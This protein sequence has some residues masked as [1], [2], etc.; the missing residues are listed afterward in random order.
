MFSKRG[1]IGFCARLK[2]NKTSLR[3][4]VIA[5]TYSMALFN[6]KTMKSSIIAISLCIFVV[7][8]PRAL[9]A[10]EIET[11]IANAAAQAYIKT[12]TV[13]VMNSYL[14]NTFNL[15]SG[16]S[17]ANPATKVLSI[18]EL[19]VSLDSLSK[20]D[21]DK[22]KFYATLKTIASAVSF[23]DPVTG[24][25][26]QFSVMI[27]SL[28][29][30]HLSLEHQEKMLTLMTQIKESQIKMAQAQNKMIQADS[31]SLEMLFKK[32]NY[33]FSEMQNYQKMLKESCPVF[34]A[35]NDYFKLDLCLRNAE[36]LLIHHEQFVGSC[37]EILSF[38]SQHINLN[39]VLDNLGLSKEKLQN[40]I[41]E[42]KIVIINMKKLVRE[43]IT[44]A[45]E[46][47]GKMIVKNAEDDAKLTSKEHFFSYCIR[48]INETKKADV[49]LSIAKIKLRKGQLTEVQLQN[50]YDL[51]A[52]AV[53]LIESKQCFILINRT[54][55]HQGLFEKMLSF[56]EDFYRELRSELEEE[57]NA[58]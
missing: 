51:R 14:N 3:V 23:V 35:A 9:T 12:S 47:L 52:G 28:A 8:A 20:A 16:S 7:T 34:S 17:A 33:A 18:V 36:A 40:Q 58:G 10:G 44:Y 49:L 1:H 11:A 24:T 56:E 43:M 13:D 42:N 4:P 55:E 50:Y 29:E 26:M 31:I 41:E 38:Y 6:S 45:A 37:K 25:F 21:T 30:A 39:S 19:G 27:V 54:P 53:E 48:D 32:L 15:P 22:A 2:S 57:R 5:I 46:A